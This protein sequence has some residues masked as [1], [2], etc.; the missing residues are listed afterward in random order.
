MIFMILYIDLTDFNRV[1]YA[2]ADGEKIY[3]RAFKV[4]PHKSHETLKKLEQFLK[5]SKRKAENIKKIVVN[6]GPG[7]YTGT[8]IGAAHALALSLAWQV[9][10]RALTKEAFDKKFQK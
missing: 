9:P 6:K 7:S 5:S 10:M 3:C 2:L 8:R 1:T 4:D